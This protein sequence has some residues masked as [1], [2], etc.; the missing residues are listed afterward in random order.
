MNTA[1]RRR[2]PTGYALRVAGHLDSHW[3]PWFGELTLCHDDDGTTTLSGDVADQAE[4]HGILTKI[5]DLGVV[6]ISVAPTDPPSA[7]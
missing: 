5:H 3:A 7:P 6:L 1:V 4:L 2:W